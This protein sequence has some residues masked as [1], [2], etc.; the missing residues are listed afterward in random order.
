MNDQ[1]RVTSS[2]VDPRWKEDAD[3]LR[4]QLQE[5]DT[6][7]E[8]QK[9]LDELSSSQTRNIEL[10]RALAA[11]ARDKER[12]SILERERILRRAQVAQA[13]SQMVYEANWA[14]VRMESEMKQ[15]KLRA[16]VF[17]DPV[18]P[19]EASAI[20]SMPPRVPIASSYIGGTKVI[21][22][23][24]S[25]I[26]LTS[27]ITGIASASNMNMQANTA[28]TTS[29]AS[30]STLP[31]IVVPEV[32]PTK[33]IPPEI[34]RGSNEI[35]P[36]EGIT[37]M[38]ANA[39]ESMFGNILDQYYGKERGVITQ[40]VERISQKQLSSPETAVPKETAPLPPPIQA[41]PAPS[42]TPPS[43]LGKIM[44][45]AG[46]PKLDENP[47]PGRTQKKI[48]ATQKGQWTVTELQVNAEVLA[49][50]CLHEK[51]ELLGKNPALL[52]ELFGLP[53]RDFVPETR[54]DPVWIDLQNEWLKQVAPAAL[55]QDKPIR[56]NSTE[57]LINEKLGITEQD[58][59]SKKIEPETKPPPDQ[60][61]P[62][63]VDLPPQRTDSKKKCVIM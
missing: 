48:P 23:L 18:V 11:V 61:I 8:R 13:T 39:A 43:V 49:S 21:D 45:P 19:P 5:L 16:M 32:R 17:T 3:R 33:D 57:A 35:E 53:K 20:G 25:D 52:A 54:I 2:T 1:K 55:V 60:T 6:E 42:S 14:R 40:P 36:T 24:K 31:Q 37:D 44:I 29:I 46:P 4:L 47:G 34:P 28:D 27:N 58:L 41:L 12:I 38:V 59:N 22:G 56:K 62:N 10:E 15:A 26:I 51:E 63:D 50:S 30:T 7:M 9:L